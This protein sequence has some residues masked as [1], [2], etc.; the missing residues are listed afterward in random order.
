M[1]AVRALRLLL[2]EREALLHG[3]VGEPAASEIVKTRRRLELARQLLEDLERQHQQ[4]ATDFV[5]APYELGLARGLK[6]AIDDLRFVLTG[7]L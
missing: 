1:W 4:C 6:M 5:A 3:A 2:D 7:E